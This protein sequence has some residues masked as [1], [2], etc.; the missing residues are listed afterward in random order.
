[1]RTLDKKKIER[2]NELAKKSKVE[3]LTNEERNEQAILRKEYLE[4]IKANFRATLDNIEV[5]DKK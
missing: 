1:M 3:G 4:M 5:V 2:I